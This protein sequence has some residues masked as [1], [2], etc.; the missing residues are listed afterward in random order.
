[1]IPINESGLLEFDSIEKE[2]KQR[3]KKIIVDTT[4]RYNKDQI[5]FYLDSSF[6]TM[7]LDGTEFTSFDEDYCR[8]RQEEYDEEEEGLYKE[9]IFIPTP[10]VVY[11]S[12]LKYIEVFTEFKD[13]D[14]RVNLYR[15]FYLDDTLSLLTFD[16]SVLM[17]KEIAMRYQREV[18][19]KRK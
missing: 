14:A 8:F 15:Q 13:I 17:I 18:L 10:N 2:F 4:D 16:L 7:F 6:S 1:M 19:D 11:V 9:C 12:H 3:L 5:Q